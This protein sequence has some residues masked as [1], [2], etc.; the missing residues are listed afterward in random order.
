MAKI[1]IINQ[2]VWPDGSPVCLISEQLSVYLTQQRVPVV[3]VGG[4][5]EYRPSSR[6]K[7]ACEVVNLPTRVF[8][9]NNVFQI[10]AE[11]ASVFRTFRRY[12]RQHVRPGDLVIITSAPFLNIL[13]RHSIRPQ[14]VTTFFWL[15][16]YFPASIFTLNAPRFLYRWV[17]KWWDWELSY[18]ETVI[19][20]SSNLGYF[21]PN[22][23]VHRQWPM[24]PIAPNPAII[25]ARKA[26]YTGNL[27][28]AHDVDALVNEC[29]QLRDAGYEINIHADGPGL[30]QLPDW[31][32][33]RSKGVFKS[34]EQLIRAL[35]EHEVHLV[36]GTPGTDELSFP[37]KLWNSIASGRRIIACGF[38]GK[39]Q[40]ELR[41]TLAA[42]YKRH[43]PDLA[44][45]ITSSF[46]LDPRNHSKT[47][48]P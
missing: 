46:Q 17:K 29:E 39:M 16:D 11:Y 31:L 8:K 44:A 40:E 22:A 26:L 43:L 34:S 33:A 23:V 24:I 4:G 47:A 37:S 12:I 38:T 6:P 35:H 7:P 42:D 2:Y 15:F 9:R 36:T 48:M 25:P 28:L 3:M 45:F 27:G 19:K 30:A 21:G 14:K 20:I 10:L 13:L 41:L 18:F 1:H 32:K 5:G